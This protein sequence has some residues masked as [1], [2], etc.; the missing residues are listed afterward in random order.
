MRSLQQ[1]CPR[2]LASLPP[3]AALLLPY[4]DLRHY[5]VR[6]APGH[7]REQLQ[8]LLVAE[9]GRQAK[10]LPSRA[11][12]AGGCLLACSR[13]P[14][15][16]PRVNDAAATRPHTP[17]TCIQCCYA[18]LSSAFSSP[19]VT[20]ASLLASQNP[21]KFPPSALWR[22]KPKLAPSASLPFLCCPP[23]SPNLSA[24]KTHALPGSTRPTR[25]SK[26]GWP[27]RLRPQQRC[28]RLVFTPPCPS[29]LKLCVPPCTMG[30]P[31]ARAFRPPSLSLPICHTCTQ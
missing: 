16:A 14:A 21:S 26:G 23:A 30:P 11:R 25:C 29:F 24:F 5:G 28:C 6:P 7:E 13:Q 19:N 8:G 17:Q 22:T 27:A 20:L 4:H 12:P 9:Q 3:L 18:Q 1:R 2:L 10:P 15:G 31:V